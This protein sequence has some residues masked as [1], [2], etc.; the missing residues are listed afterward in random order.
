MLPSR[1]HFAD[2]CV[3]E[4]YNAVATQIHA[5]LAR[6]IPAI[7]FATDIWSS[8]AKA[9]V[10]PMTDSGLASFSCLANTLQLTVHDGILSQPSI[11]DE[12]V[13]GRKIVR[14]FK[15]SPPTYSCP[16]TLTAHHWGLVKSFITLVSIFEQLT[17]EVKSSGASAA[18]A[19][20]SVRALR[21]LLSK[22]DHGVKTTKTALLE[23]VNKHFHQMDSDPIFCI[24]TL[25]DPRNK[26]HYF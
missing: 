21:C 14:H 12:V 20:L 10:K 8:D 18:D 19:I 9:T 5:L 13:I 16:T 22:E 2:V 17:R 11:S 4:I 23:I 7:S 15:H 24:T 26:D 3:P 6:Y 25:L 1:R